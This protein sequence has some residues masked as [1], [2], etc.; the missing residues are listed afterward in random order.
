M[1][2]HPVEIQPLR[3][4][5]ELTTVG[6]RR[7]L[8]DL[9]SG[10]D[11]TKLSAI[12]RDAVSEEVARRGMDE[13]V[14]SWA[15]IAVGPDGF[16]P[17]GPASPGD[18]VKID[19]GAVVAG[20]SADMARTAVVG[21]PS[22]IQREVH[23]ALLKAFDDGVAAL[24]P[25]RPLREAHLAATQAMHRAGFAGYSRG[26]FGH[27]LG[28]TLFNEEWPFISAQSDVLLEPGM[29]IAFETP[30]YIRGLGGF[31]IEDQFLVGPNGLELMSLLSRALH[32][33][34]AG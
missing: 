28:A 12:W 17:G 32:E 18:V 10:L 29:V 34:P 1:I 25:G 14:S 2:K 13:P 16:A 5:V 8:T 6:L 23:A 19:V 24:L 22:A 26:H 30:Y 31:I 27:S 21:T 15:Y 33:A 4:A 11:A 9:A 3:T 20:Y 7:V